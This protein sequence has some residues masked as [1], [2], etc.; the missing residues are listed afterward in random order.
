MLHKTKGIVFRLTKYGETS[1]IV[2]IFTEQFGLRGYIVNGVR[3]KSTTNKIALY[4]PLTLVDLVVY[5]REHANLERIKEIKC[6]HPFH[7][8]TTDIQKSSIAM[9]ISEIM[10]K[11]VREE[12]P[13][14]ELFEFLFQTIQALDSLPEGYENFHLIFLLKLS[15]YLG[16]GAHQVNEV[17]GGRPADVATEQ[18]IGKLVKAE[19]QE[20]IA[21]THLQRRTALELLIQFYA[22]HIDNLGEIR[23]V[24]VLREV[25]G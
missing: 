11:T 14:A 24:Q 19:Y 2:N 20:H 6:L 3:G 12:S 25:L 18:T 4:Q 10:N 9:F 16:F 8:I 22:D 1:I 17:V 15:R 5:H 21:L 23:S 13:N 7:S